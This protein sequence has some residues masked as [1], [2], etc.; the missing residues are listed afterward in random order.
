VQSLRSFTDGDLQWTQPSAFRREYELR[1]GDE[2][3]GTLRYAGAFRSLASA[4]CADGT[5]T[6][7]RFGL[8]SGSVVVRQPDAVQD[9]ATYRNSFWKVGGTLQLQ[10]GRNFRVGGSFRNGA[11]E[12]ESDKGQTLVRFTR[13]RGS[14]HMS[15]NVEITSAGREA[16]ELP[17]LVFLGWYLILK[18]ENDMAG[19][20]GA[21][22]AAAG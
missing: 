13:V 17:W 3:V 10:G 7:N 20:A 14:F 15:A 1:A 18:F 16:E 19:A 9:V 8:L 21:A 5:W 11:L 12:I 4:E 22:A 2:R 6:L